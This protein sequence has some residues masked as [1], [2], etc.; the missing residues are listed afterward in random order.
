VLDTKTGQVLVTA[1]G[2][3]QAGTS[4]AG[5]FLTDKDAMK[6]FIGS[7]PPDWEKKNLQ[8]VLHTNV[9]NGS[10]SAPKIIATAYW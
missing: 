4:A 8:I 6:A 3:G 7:A 9:I 2:L 5:E 1:A 10:P